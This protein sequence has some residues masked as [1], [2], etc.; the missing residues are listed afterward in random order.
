MSKVTRTAKLPR[1]L[2]MF[3]EAAIA[4]A[5]RRGREMSQFEFCQFVIDLDTVVVS[6]GNGPNPLVPR[7]TPGLDVHPRR[8]TIETNLNTMRTSKKGVFAGGDIVTGAA[9]VIGSNSPGFLTGP[10]GG[11]VPLWVSPMLSRICNSSFVRSIG[12]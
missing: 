3:S 6:I 2:V 8:G 7:T 1:A 4:A 12:R 9:T 11:A 5:V 10:V